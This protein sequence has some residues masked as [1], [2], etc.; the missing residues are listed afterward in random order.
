MNDEE[1]KSENIEEITENNIEEE[2]AP[3]PGDELSILKE[4]LKEQGK[5][6]EEYL[7]YI[8]YLKADFE[9]YK[10][11]VFKEK[12]EIWE[13]SK[14]DLIRG[15]LPIV[16]NF[17]RA[18]NSF[19]DGSS[20]SK[21]IIEGINIIYRQLKE[22]LAN[23]GVS[24]INTENEIFNPDLH[25][26]ISYEDTKEYPHGFILEEVQKGYK[27]KD[28]VI[29]VSKVKV[30]RNNKYETLENEKVEQNANK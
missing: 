15:L 28:R 16:D 30:A 8:Q 14:E 29:R 26:V 10:K 6:L 18:I 12:Q 25:E 21:D 5:H 4:K 23:L 7:K 13:L 24:E 1:I 20:N 3:E 9:N 17:E 2:Q 11:R 22:C 27:L 19:S